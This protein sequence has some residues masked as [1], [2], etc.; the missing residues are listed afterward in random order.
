GLAGVGDRRITLVAERQLRR[1]DR[2]R[3]LE[4][5]RG[6]GDRGPWFVGR[7]RARA[8]RGEGEERENGARGDPRCHVQNPPISAWSEALWRFRPVS[9][10]AARFHRRLWRAPRA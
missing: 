5:N 7:R 1:I 2:R 4:P 8:A 10:G 6:L 9:C 3:L